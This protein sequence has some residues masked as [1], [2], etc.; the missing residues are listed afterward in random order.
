V[1]KTATTTKLRIG[2][3]GAGYIGKKHVNAWEKVAGS[4]VTAVAD[5]DQEKRLALSAHANASAFE[6]LDELLSATRIDILDVCLPTPLHA[7]A[8]IAGLES[9][10]NVIV[11]KPFALTLDEID[12]MIAKERNSPGRLMV[13]HMGRFKPEYMYCKNLVDSQEL[14]A[15]LFFNAWRKSPTP[16]WSWNNWLLRKAESGGTIMDL[17]IHDLDFANWL[18]GSPGTC[19]AYEVHRSGARG[20][21]HAISDIEFKNGTRALIEGGQLMPSGYPFTMGFRLLF[22]RGSLEYQYVDNQGSS[23]FEYSDSSSRSVPKSRLPDICA[24]SPY[25]E[26]LRHFSSCVVNNRPFKI[27][28]QDARLAVETALKLTKTLETKERN[29]NA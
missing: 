5:I 8:V 29:Q 22:D 17:S 23:F 2:V 16:D 14:G 27:T 25:A 3:L 19:S 11:E 4:A 9:G 28:L 7:D 26:E 15:P 20:P 10:V 18:F 13:A 1:N 21:S 24:D 6:S 12:L